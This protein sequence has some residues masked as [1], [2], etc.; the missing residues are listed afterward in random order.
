MSRLLKCAAVAS[1]AAQGPWPEFRP[2]PEGDASPEPAP[3]AAAA[4]EAE[5]MLERAREEAAAI[6]EA[7]RREGYAEGY[8]EG[9]EA[10]RQ[11]LGAGFQAVRAL[12]LRVLAERARADEELASA[13]LE[14]VRALA[15]RLVGE[16]LTHNPEYMLGMLRRAADGLGATEH[17]EVRVHPRDVAAVAAA[18]GD[19]DG[20]LA[21][22]RVVEDPALRPGDLI[23]VSPRGRIDLRPEVQ[24]RRLL[25]AAGEE[26]GDVA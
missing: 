23:L 8:R 6:R 26:A 15:E 17:L 9:I 12:L 18:A 2:E 21:R 20:V 5:R 19:Q 10:A 13:V 4:E 14:L 24:I 16:A 3:D 7:A 11:R 1:L 22:V 25:E